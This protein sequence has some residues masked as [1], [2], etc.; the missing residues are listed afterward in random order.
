[1]SA[2]VLMIL[3]LL[4]GV[5]LFLYGMGVMGDG[6]KKVAGNQME[7]ILYKLT[8]SP[9]K[10]FLLG[11]AVTAVIQSSSATTV[12]VV[13]FVN[14]GMMKVSQAVGVILGANIGTSITGWIVCLS[15]IDAGSGIASFLSSATITAVVA[16][17]GILLH[18]FAK[19][20]TLVH[21]GSIMMGFAVLMT[22]MS[23]MSGAVSPLRTNPVFIEIMSSL[24]NPIVGI[25]FGI[26][27]A[28]VL[29]SVSASVGVLQALSTT[30]AITF[31]AAYPM[32]L[33][34]GVGASVPVLLASIGANK[35]GKRTAVLYLVVC[36]IGLI[37][38][39][40][41][42]YPFN[43][44]LNFNFDA[45]I[46]NPFSIATLNTLYRIIV[47]TLMLPLYKVIERI[48]FIC[49]PVSESETEDKAEFELLEERFLTNPDVAYEQSMIVMNGM[50]KNA[51]KN[52]IRSLDLID[53]YSEEGYRKVLDLEQTLNKYEDKLG[54]YLM[55]ISTEGVSDEQGR[56][57]NKAL[58]AISD[59]EKIG[60]YSL[61]MADVARHMDRRKRKFSLSALDEVT[62]VSTAAAEI[63]EIT[64]D[65][66]ING[67][68]KEIRRVFP[69]NEM[70][71]MDCN[72][73]K[74][75]HVLRL[76]SGEC[77]LE[78]GFE[79]NDLLNDIQQIGN[80]CANLALDIIKENEADFNLHRFLTKYQK[81][82]KSEFMD[83][84]QEY[85]VKYALQSFSQEAS[86]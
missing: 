78:K 38:G 33:G 49:I 3:S 21:L 84:L 17:I 74:K 8:N 82:N 20:D 56:Q 85:E 39:A 35:N 10:G 53:N 57:I 19:N 41:L 50:A 9:L 51:K 24:T 15:Y 55:K 67:D 25:L 2:N 77:E 69:L 16:I 72:E 68:P 58:Q 5:A 43:G 29:Q 73:I 70:I 13:G 36:F 81:E 62:V 59:F 76:K 66:F 80:H 47:M 31:M 30:G 37:L 7:L 52:V 45:T 26:L 44:L 64:V 11:T 12:M 23:M 28:A 54:N 83:V 71:T 32:I 61:N 4:S 14:S 46:M 34:M 22:G 48:L 6:L 1:M 65:G 27:F 63:I 42:Y 60:D 79:L 75:R 18:M 86:V 40:V